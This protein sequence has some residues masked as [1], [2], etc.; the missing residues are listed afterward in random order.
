MLIAVGQLTSSADLLANGHA[1]ASLARE[2]AKGGARILFLPEASDYLARNTAHSLELA[3]PVTNSPFI[4]TLQSAIRSLNDAGTPI[5]VLV[6]VHEPAESSN[7]VRNTA[8]Y[9]SAD[10]SIKYRYQKLHLFDVDLPTGPI[11][12][13]SDSVEPGSQLPQV[14][15]TPAGKLGVGICYDLRFP[16]HALYN[17]SHGAQIL[18]YPSA[19]TRPTGPH[20]RKL[21]AATAIFTQCY[22]ILPA[23]TGIHTGANNRESWG[24]AAVLDPWGD[25]VAACEESDTLAF[26]QIDLDFLVQVRN[27]MPLHTQRRNDVFINQPTMFRTLQHAPSVITLFH[28]PASKLSQKLLT[29]LERAQDL[30]ADRSGEYRFALDKC[31]S[32]PTKEQFEFINDT[33]TGDNNSKAF[34]TA[35]PNGTLDSFVPP[36]AVDW[37]HKRLAVTETDLD[38]LLKTFRDNV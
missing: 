22:V 36:L 34:S 27:K 13:E 30:T 10:G 28:S 19:W 21:G 9:F 38:F 17:A 20:F 35:F 33:V 23:Q 3:T 24:H 32:V 5:D 2:A 7:R 37:D 12:R 26:A 25:T 11:F 31:T 1:A 29:Q 18:V 6:G 14:L 4:T 8:L 15:D 16:E